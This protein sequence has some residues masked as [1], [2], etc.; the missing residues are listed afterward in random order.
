MNNRLARRIK[1]EKNKVKELT[2]A[3]QEILPKLK[4]F[5]NELPMKDRIRMAWRIINGR[6]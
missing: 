6:F 4:A 3:E 1:A 2:K 5:L